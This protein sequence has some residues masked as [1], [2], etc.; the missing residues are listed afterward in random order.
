MPKSKY[1]E[2]AFYK[3][4]WL[5][6]R[7]KLAN[8]AASQL[9][10]ARTNILR[11]SIP[12]EPFKINIGN[13]ARIVIILVGT[14]GTGSYVSRYLAQ[15][16]YTLRALGQDIRLILVD[17]DQVEPKNVGRQDFCRAEVGRLKAE[18]LA[19]RYQE[20]YG[21]PITAIADKFRA[22]I[23]EQF[24]PTSS[25]SGTLT[26]VVGAVDSWEAR[27]DIAEAIEAALRQRGPDTPDK[28]WW[29]DAGNERDYGQVLSG[30]SLSPVPLLSPLGF[31]FGLPLPHLQ[32]GTLVARRQKKP[33]A[34]PEFSCAELAWLG[35]QDALINKMVATWVAY[36]VFHLIVRNDLAVMA[37]YV[38]LKTGRVSSSPI[39]GGQY[40]RLHASSSCAGQ[41][42][43]TPVAT[44]VMAEPTAEI[45]P[46]AVQC[47]DCEELMTRGTTT[48]DGVEL[49]VLF[50]RCG[51]HEEGCPRCLGQVRRV[52]H[53]VPHLICD[54]CRWR[55]DIPAAYRNPEAVELT[56]VTVGY[57]EGGPEAR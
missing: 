49:A 23:L 1:L 43:I 31:C 34:E 5:Y 10:T 50:C 27:R 35:E 48:R 19:R 8:W 29:V 18:T 11:L 26:L 25:P 4:L 22:E 56:E 53:P 30:N 20:A 36:H 3:E 15:L 28:I 37:T 2:T 13:P 55:A 33:S 54:E 14:G 51:R 12:K 17:P 47:P 21:M 6:G 39:E 45:D 7:W 24:R 32:D 16:M 9:Q 57:E 38:D 41:P 40:V 42:P 52:E 46:N 44:P